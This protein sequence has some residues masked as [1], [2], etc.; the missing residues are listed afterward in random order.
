[1]TVVVSKLFLLLLQLYMAVLAVCSI[2]VKVDLDKVV[3]E[4]DD[5]F[6][7]VG[8]GTKIVNMTKWGGFN[9]NSQTLINM[10]K[11]LSPGYLRVG[12]TSADE[13][14]FIEKPHIH[15]GLG[16]VSNEE[17]AWAKTGNKTRE[18]TW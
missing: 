16:G 11:E 4:V 15:D 18:P 5:R 8:L 14:V 12:G 9:T 1:M 13:A 3:N 10:V 17:L 6:L 7:S 2:L